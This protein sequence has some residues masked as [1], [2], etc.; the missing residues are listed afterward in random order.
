MSTAAVSA[1]SIYQQL[2]TF[3]QQRNQ[4]LQQ[5]GQDLRNGDLA[6]AQQD[7][8]TVQALGESGPFANGDVFKVSQRDQD[9]EAIGQALQS[10]DLTGAQQAFSELQSTYQSGSQ[11]TSPV[12]TIVVNLGG[13][14]SASAAGSATSASASGDSTQQSAS[15]AAP[16]SGSSG[17]EIVL[18]LGSASA[19]E[20][21]TIGVN[22]AGNGAEQV[23]IGIADGQNQKPEQIVLNLSQN[24]N[25]QIVL[26]FLNSSASSTSQGGSVNTTA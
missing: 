21:I 4:D 12:Q 23:T 17:P 15:A 16:S 5:L 20:Q 10:G 6:D 2:Q 14:A 7:Y 11:N 3:F 22:N 19:G 24:S 8:Q 1:S 25:E 26:N 9:F 18:N 13:A